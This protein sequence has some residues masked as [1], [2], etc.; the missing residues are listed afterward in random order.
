M[1]LEE[2]LNIITNGDPI[3]LTCVYA[4][5]KRQGQIYNK[6]CR[7]GA[8]DGH[9]RKPKTQNSKL[10]TSNTEGGHKIASFIENGNIP[11]AERDE[12]TGR[13][14]EFFSPNIYHIIAIN[15]RKIY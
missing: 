13:F 10:E 1:S 6:I 3:T 5:G 4:Q 8:T 9:E 14:T 7:Y 2:A 15:G 11:M 12:R